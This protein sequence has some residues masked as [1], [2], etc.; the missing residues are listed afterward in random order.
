MQF[1]HHQHRSLGRTHHK[2]QSCAIAFKFELA[3]EAFAVGTQ[4]ATIASIV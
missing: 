3:K 2:R 1:L 4:T